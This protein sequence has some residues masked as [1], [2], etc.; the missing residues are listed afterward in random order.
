MIIRNILQALL[1]LVVLLLCST[2]KIKLTSWRALRA[3]MQA[4]SHLNNK[5]NKSA[6]R[7]KAHFLEVTGGGREEVG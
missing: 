2:L 7:A 1:S 6:L 3:K 4:Y 5:E